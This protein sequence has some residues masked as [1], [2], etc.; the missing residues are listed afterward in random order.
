MAITNRFTPY[1][2]NNDKLESGILKTGVTSYPGQALV[3][4]ATGYLDV[5][6]KDTQVNIVGVSAEQ[7]VGTGSLAHLYYPAEQGNQFQV[8][9]EEGADTQTYIGAV[10]SLADA[11]A[12]LYKDNAGTAINSISCWVDASDETSA[13]VFLIEGFLD[14]DMDST[15]THCFGRFV[16]T[17]Y[18]GKAD[19]PQY[20]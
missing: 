10:V 19:D 2:M 14:P 7:T 5:A 12:S 9:M 8:Y 13:P 16:D 6:V 15:D 18:G 4:D 1:K 3:Y 20:A 11:T 17:A